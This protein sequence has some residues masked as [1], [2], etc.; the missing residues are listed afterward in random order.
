MNAYINLPLWRGMAP[1]QKKCRSRPPAKKQPADLQDDM[2]ALHTTPYHMSYLPLPS[3]AHNFP[4]PASDRCDIAVPVH[5]SRRSAPAI[6]RFNPVLG[7]RTMLQL[8]ARRA[9]ESIAFSAPDRNALWSRAQDGLLV[10]VVE[11][12]STSDVLGRDWS[13]VASELP[14]RLP[15]QCKDRYRLA[16]TVAEL[17]FVFLRVTFLGSPFLTILARAHKRCRLGGF[18]TTYSL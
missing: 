8:L 17:T 1:W 6:S 3:M 11:K 13:E 7:W 4:G 15:Q 14:W 18:C 10:Q 16:E 9:A 2:T 5:P 12:H